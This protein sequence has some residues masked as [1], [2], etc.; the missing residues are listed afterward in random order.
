MKFKKFCIANF[1]SFFAN[2]N[3]DALKV[4]ITLLAKKHQIKGSVILAPEGINCS[5]SGNFS[6]IEEIVRQIKDLTSSK[7]WIMHLNYAD[8]NPFLKLKIRIKTEIVSIGFPELE[9]PRLK[10]T[11]VSPKKWRDFI[12]QSD[13]ILID[14]RNNYEFEMGHFDNAVNPGTENFRDFSSWLNSQ[15]ENL[16]NKKV[17]MYCTGGIRC[18]KATAY[19]R[20]YLNFDQAYQLEGGILEY[21]RQFGESSRAWQGECFVFD[22]RISVDRALK[23]K[24]EAHLT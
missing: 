12:S 22:D 7:D 20:N 3:L 21:L 15:A 11:Y 16:K 23:A 10:G 4:K 6:N 14:V 8:F 19:L 9:V 13:V 17:A 18:E 1:Y 24:Q 2:D 5:L